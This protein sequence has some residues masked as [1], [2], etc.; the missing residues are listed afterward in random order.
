MIHSGAIRSGIRL[1]NIL[2]NLVLPSP[3]DIKVTVGE[4]EDFDRNMGGVYCRPLE[5]FGVP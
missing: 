2:E 4:G 1:E 3:V 5:M